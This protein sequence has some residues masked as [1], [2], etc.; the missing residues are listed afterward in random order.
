[1]PA[2]G[3][4]RISTSAV[5]LPAPGSASAGGRRSLDD[6]PEA[7]QIADVFQVRVLAGLRAVLRVQLDGALKVIECFL[8]AA[9]QAQGRRHDVVGVIVFRILLKRPLKVMSAVA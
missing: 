9:T 8:A 3:R 6:P 5:A 4:T 2:D 7:V 1:M